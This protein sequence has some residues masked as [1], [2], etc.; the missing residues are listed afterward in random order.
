M[1]RVH[2]PEFVAGLAPVPEAV[3][4]HGGRIF[5]QLEHGGLRSLE[6][7]HAAYRERHPD[8]SQLAVSRPPRALRALDQV[9]VFDIDA[10]VLST[11][12]VRE[13]ARDF[14]RSAGYLVD[15]GYDGIHIAGANM[16]IVQQFL[17]PYYNRRDDEFGDGVRFLERVHD[18]IREEA[19]EVPLITKVPVET[20]FPRPLRRRRRITLEDGVEIARRLEAIGY[21]GVV[22]VT[23]SPFWDTNLVRGKYPERAWASSDLQPGYAEAFGGQWR[24]R[25]VAAAHRLHSWWVEEEPAWNRRFCRRVREA[26]SIPVCCEGGIRTRAEIDRL[27]DPSTASP[28]NGSGESEP[29]ADLVGLG[30]PFYAEPRLG[31]RLLDGEEGRSAGR[32]GAESGSS[33]VRD[34]DADRVLCRDCNN[35]TIPQVTGARGTCRTPS[36]VRE[37]ARLE[38]EGVYDDRK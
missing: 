13:L 17:S 36:I 32:M 19:G 22:P 20:E 29:A 24:A 8:F 7:W 5:C 12:E 38:K 18:A 16:G 30:R 25:A 34:R 31:T 9:G 2:D 6:I 28:E 4:D 1:T 23:G 11:A 21:D 10:H 37:R 27:L 35:C 15:A 33:P 14:G 3:H 26:V